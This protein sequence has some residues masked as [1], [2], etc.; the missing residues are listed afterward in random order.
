MLTLALH[1]GE[2]AYNFHGKALPEWVEP[3][4]ALD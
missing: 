3:R 4:M 2:A 1:L